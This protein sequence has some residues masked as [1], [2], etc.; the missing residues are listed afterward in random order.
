MMR[1]LAPAV[2]ALS[3]LA[4]C[5]GGGGGPDGQDEPPLPV[6]TLLQGLTNLVVDI[7]LE[8]NSVNYITAQTGSLAG[9]RRIVMRYRVECD[10]GVKILPKGFPSLG[11]MLT[12]YFQRQ[13]DDWS[14]KGPFEAYRW[15]AKFSS[16][17]PIVAGEYEIEASLDQ[18]WTAVLTSSRKS[19][20]AGFADAVNNAERIGFVLGGGDGVGHGIYATGRARI[21][22]LSFTVE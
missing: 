4:A 22:V 14:A 9:K 5:G 18:D 16:Q 10:P 11:S 15:Y 7:P 2:L 17:R 6:A 8:G 21:V 1:F 20:P 12:L 19:N 13:G 3:V